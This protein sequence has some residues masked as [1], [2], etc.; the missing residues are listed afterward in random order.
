MNHNH[1]LVTGSSG[2]VGTELS[3]QLLSQGYRLTG[4]DWKPNRWSEKINNQTIELD[5]RSDSIAEKLPS[6]IDLIVHLGANAR[7]YKLI[8]SPE[9]ARDNFLTT[10]NILEYA[11]NI[12]ADVVFA[13]SRE[14]YGNGEKIIH[15][16]TD[17]Y[18]DE[19]ESPYTASKVGGEALATSYDNCYDINVSILRFSN[20]YG[21][22]D[23]SDRVVPLF[24]AQA[25]NDN[26]MV[27]YGG[28]KLLDFTHVEDCVQGTM[29]T[30]KNFRK[31]QNTTF[32]IASGRGSSLVDLAKIV[33]DTLKSNSSIEVEN[34]RT[35]EVSRYVANIDKAQRILGYEPKYE[36]KEG[37]QNTV[38]WYEDQGLYDEI[39]DLNEW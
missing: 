5:L 2:T 36:L 9:K 15:D 37:I 32:N 29:K 3:L 28:N 14:V 34:A 21:R 27:I 39:L 16:E 12:G 1:I 33:H 19:C 17:T 25:A 35:G 23:L 18:V 38:D 13:S 7:V 11:R 30:I 24:I 6:D 10:F 31:S 26:K 22:Y 8:E 20:V 4:V